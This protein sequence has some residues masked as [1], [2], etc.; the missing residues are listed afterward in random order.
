MHTPSDKAVR[1]D[2]LLKYP[3]IEDQWAKKYTTGSKKSYDGQTHRQK[4]YNFL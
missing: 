1:K 2:S 3:H 4:L